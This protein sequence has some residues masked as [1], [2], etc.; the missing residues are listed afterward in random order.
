M[1]AFNDHV[2]GKL[3]A[4]EIAAGLKDLITD[5]LNTHDAYAG[6]CTNLRVVGDGSLKTKLKLAAETVMNT[7]I[8]G[9]IEDIITN[10][11]EKQAKRQLVASDLK[12]LKLIDVPEEESFFHKALWDQIKKIRAFA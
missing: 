5:A 9:H 1:A 12:L 8:T 2:N 3:G 7:Y 10:V 4:S 11:P 6:T